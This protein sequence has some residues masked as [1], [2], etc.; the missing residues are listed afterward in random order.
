MSTFAIVAALFARSLTGEGQ[1]VHTSLANQS[2]LLQI[3][4]LTT[5]PGAPAPPTGARD[6]TGERALERYYECADGWIGIA[7]TTASSCAALVDALGLDPVDVHGA[8]AEGPDGVLASRI[9][10]AIRPLPVE[11]VLTRLGDAGV[12][13]TPVL[14]LDETFADPFLQENGF[15]ESYV[16]PAFGPASGNAGFARF[17]GTTVAFRRPAPMLGEHSAEVLRDFGIT[18]ARIEALLDAGATTQSPR[19]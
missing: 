13:A 17:A 18:Q 19:P 15:Y 5:Y 8:L 10:D 1:E 3:G 7:C 9:A 11:G 12:P 14:T 2:V 6:C 4:A 16:D